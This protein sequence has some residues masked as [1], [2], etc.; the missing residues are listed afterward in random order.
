MIRHSEE[1]DLL[2]QG[3]IDRIS[4]HRPSSIAMALIGFSIAVI[5]GF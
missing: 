2:G 3:G 1:G 4:R 5:S